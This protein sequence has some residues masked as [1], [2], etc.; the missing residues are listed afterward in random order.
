MLPV[1]V[2][3]PGKHP[4]FLP[5]STVSASAVFL[6]QGAQLRCVDELF[7]SPALTKTDPLLMLPPP[8]YLTTVFL[9]FQTSTPVIFLSLNHP[10]T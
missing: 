8:S 1:P 5:A 4:A 7:L 6:D 2:E 10:P 9:H 3:V